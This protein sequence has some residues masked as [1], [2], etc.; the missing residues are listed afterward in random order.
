MSS[1]LDDVYWDAERV[2]RFPLSLYHN[3]F[4]KLNIYHRS[5]FSQS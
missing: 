4:A 2:D 1:A 3:Q 5:H